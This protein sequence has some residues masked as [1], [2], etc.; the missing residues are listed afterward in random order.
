MTR[1]ELKE[2]I[3]DVIRENSKTLK[4]SSNN[5]GTNGII[6]KG[7]TRGAANGPSLSQ[8]NTQGTGTGLTRTGKSSSST[9]ES[10]ESYNFA[11]YLAD[12]GKLKGK[13]FKV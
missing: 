12:N 7:I 2:I 10:G 5:N 3:K 4:E 13:T 8:T 11:K 6:S 1:G 9:A